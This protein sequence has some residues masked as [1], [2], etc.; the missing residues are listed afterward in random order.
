MKAG[1]NSLSTL[2][3]DIHTQHIAKKVCIVKAW[4]LDGRGN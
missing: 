1:F 3:T 4:P 2:R